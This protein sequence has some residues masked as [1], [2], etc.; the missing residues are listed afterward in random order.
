MVAA[1]DP[2][3]V[4]TLQ[5]WTILSGNDDGIFA[6]NAATG[7]L[8]V[9]DNTNLDF[10]TTS[11]YTLFLAVY[12]GP[13]MSG[14]ESV[15][16]NV[17]NVN[18]N[19]PLAN[20]D[21]YTINEDNSLV[22]DWWNTDWSVRQKLTFQNIDQ[23]TLNDF[24][25]LVVLN[26]GNI[27]YAKTQSGG[28]D[29][30]F[31]DADGAQLPYEIEEWNESGDSY[32]W[33][34]IPQID[35]ASNSDY[36]WMYYGNAAVSSQENSIAVWDSNYVGVWHL[37]EEQGGAGN[38]GV[39]QD[40]TSNNNDGN[41]FV[42]A[43]GQE[44][45]VGGGQQFSGNGD[46]IE[47][48]HDASL[49]LTGSITISFWLKPTEDT[50]TFNRIVEKGLWGYQT[51]YYFG[52]GDGT[53]D[54][55]FYLNDTEVHD[56]ADGLL[57]VN[58]WQHAAVSYDSATGNATLFLNGNPIASGN[59]SGPITGNADSLLISHS[60]STYDFAG[61]I[62]EIRISGSAR[63]N[64]W[65][66]AQYKAMNN[67]PGNAFVSFGGE[68]LAPA[69]GGVIANDTD[70]DGDPLTATL[71]SGPTQAASFVLNKDGTFTYTP[72]ANYHGSDVFTYEVSDGNGG[73]AQATA[74]ITINP[75][76][77]S[78]TVATN[79]G[80]T[81][82]EGSIGNIITKA[83]L[84]EGDPDD[85]GAGL[86]YTLTGD[87][88][89]G[90]LRLNGTVLNTNDTF[91]QADI[92]AGIVTYD[93]DGS[94][95]T[96]DSFD[97]S[98]ADGGENGSIPAT[99]TFSINV[100]AVDD[101]AP[102]QVNNTGSTVAEG[103]SDTLITA[104][105][106]FTDSEQP[107]TSVTYTVTG[108]LANGQLELT[109]GPGVAVTSFTQDDINNNRVVYVHDGSNTTSD[110]ITF[111]VDDGQ[112]NS[113]TGQ[114][115]NLTV[116][117]VDD[118]APTQVNNTGSTVAEGGTD[119]ISNTELRYDD[120]EQP[121][122][123]VLYT[124]TAG[125]ANGQFELTTNAGVAVTSFTQA[126]IDA[127]QVVYVHDGSNTTS[128]SIS[129]TVD[130]GQGN[131]LAGQSF[132]LT[133][134]AVD[135]DAPTQVNNTGSTVA[136]GGTDTLITAELLFTDSE[137]PATSMTYTVTGGSS[138]RPVGTDHRS[139]RGRDELH[140]GRHQQQPGGLCPRR[141]QHHL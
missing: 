42:L 14:G 43:T 139:G 9:A 135:D 110:S 2:D 86:I 123:S 114:S 26:S 76:N 19:F 47:V 30:R 18:D 137:Q 96:G 29:L 71:V 54:L 7:E 127:N 32:V 100:T 35:G 6:I 113:L 75:V 85:S 34:R 38:T 8:T 126:Q 11:S 102:V 103:G 57:A 25:V 105:L 78:P 12:D 5:N 46:W 36:T 118:T 50:S 115:F 84:N 4:G 13:N 82:D 68:E 22:V 89:N 141:Q 134:T 48:P 61:Y 119:T 73:T 64:D 21:S 104:E 51:A 109:A 40:S 66:A 128:D 63:T 112:G 24:P 33:V 129:F 49:N 88:G 107:A 1:T 53:N 17:T 99:G 77:D 125:P 52:L 16:I 120:S 3:T 97:F 67:D 81:F 27:D 133:V 117:A 80:A 37:S 41:D 101:D 55:T 138:Q 90:T 60:D 136:E 69:I 45:R 44:G 62:D 28:G 23:G 65:I 39:Y 15:E 92:D 83:M 95:T 116:T 59:Y 74:T 10:E 132:N 20:D 106:L 70:L 94:N 111:T 108:G 56:T 124:I 121:A 131:S 91:T 122:S 87:V 130:D 58:T 140:P 31:L 72:I 79:T 98:L 93:H